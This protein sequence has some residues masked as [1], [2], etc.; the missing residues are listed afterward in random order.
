MTNQDPQF[1]NPGQNPADPPFDGGR[2]PQYGQPAQGGAA[3][4]YGPPV[5]SRFGTQAYG[6]DAPYGAPVAEPAKFRTL[7]TLTLL[8]AVLYLLSSIPGLFMD[9]EGQTRAQLEQAG[10]S[11]EE[12]EQALQFGGTVGVISAV[13]IL[14]IGLGLYALVYFGLKSV[15]NWARI[16]GIVL[17]ILSVVGAVL[18]MLAAGLLAGL[19]M[20]TG[21]DLSSPLGIVATV[22]SLAG[23]VVNI[24]WLV[25]AFNKDVAAYT[26]QGRRVAA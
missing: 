7:L 26:K 15:K 12:I 21:L 11:P 24:L 25:H 6:A 4:P 22:L 20:N 5:G 14:L 1:Q 9:T 17:A 19:G 23:L 3:D 10:M 18:G 16:L 8:S 13:A 2:A